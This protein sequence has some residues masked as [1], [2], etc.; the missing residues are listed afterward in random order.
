M[1]LSQLKLNPRHRRARIEMADRYELHRTLLKAFPPTLPADERVLYR[2]ETDHTTGAA[3]VLLQSVHAPNWDAADHLHSTGYLLEA[4]QIRPVTPAVE[5][6]ARLPFRLQA[7]PTVKRDGKRHALYADD[8][9]LAWIQRKGQ[10]HGFAADALELR[11]NKM[12][13]M[14]GKNGSRRM[15]WHVV[16]FDGILQVTDNDTFAAALI[17]GIGSAKSFGCGLISVPYR[18]T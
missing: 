15:T 14:H 17:G 10:Q 16:Q 4:P 12:G 3:T 7:N 13:N 11:V 9:L 2:V 1:Y 6:G 18:S 5:A 8:A